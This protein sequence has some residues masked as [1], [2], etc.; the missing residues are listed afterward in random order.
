MNSRKRQKY[1]KLMFECRKRIETL[2]DLASGEFGGVYLQVLI[3]TEALQLR[4]LLELIAFSS[5]IS[6]EAAYR[7]VTQNIDGVWKA[8]RIMCE[9][10]KINQNFYPLPVSEI[11]NDGWKKLKGGYLTKKQFIAL[12]D[13]CSTHIHVRNP[14]RVSENSLA[15]HKK[16][17]A[18]LSRIESLL[19]RHIVSLVDDMELLFVEVPHFEDSTSP[20]RIRYLVKDDG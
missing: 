16:V 8:K 17:P 10:G 3:E 13:E 4:K 2:H 15:F 20:I 1:L 5:L 12:Y 18:Y 6:H 14:Y 7:T 9:L 19:S 11:T